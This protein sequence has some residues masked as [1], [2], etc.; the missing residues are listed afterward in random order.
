M[1]NRGEKRKMVTRRD[2]V[3]LA[4][5]GAGALAL[6]A[7]FLPATGAF[8]ATTSA[9]TGLTCPAVDSAKPV[10]LK[11][12]ATVSASEAW[13]VGFTGGTLHPVIE[14]FGG[15]NWSVVSDPALTS[16]GLLN[17]VARFPGGAWAVGASG[18]PKPGR[19][20]LIFAL[21]GTSV[22]AESLP[23]VGTGR[24][25]TVSAT[26]A[27]DAWAGGFINKGGSLILHWNGKSWARSSFAGKGGVSGIVGISKNNAWAIDTPGTGVSQIWHWNGKSWSRASLPSVP[28][29]PSLTSISASSAKD[30]WAVGANRGNDP[31]TTVALHFNGSKWRMANPK[32]PPTTDG[33]FLGGV[34]A[35]S[36]KN[37][38]A[39][40]Q[41]VGFPV[42]TE[43]W[44]GTAWKQVKA[45]AC[46]QLNAVSAASD[47][48]TWAVGGDGPTKALILRFKAHKWVVISS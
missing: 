45:P 41:D 5:L 9:T 3:G 42:L 27:R 37:A 46:G 17:A 1:S 33:D 23:N 7:A 13:A 29:K 8:A 18:T 6:G 19:T 43:R 10:S 11:G 48:T 4:V 36:A 39:V 38:W 20:P 21:G 15:T 40:G 12:V 25:T 30:V 31:G 35:S 16:P 2:G 44:N 32:N 24:L 22:R 14:H 26:S 47:G 34:S 28:G